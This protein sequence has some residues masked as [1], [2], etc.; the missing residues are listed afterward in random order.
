MNVSDVFESKPFI[1]NPSVIKLIYPEEESSAFDKLGYKYILSPLAES[2]IRQA[3][4]E[5][6]FLTNKNLGLNP[7]PVIV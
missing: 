2:V 6:A 4:E 1:L 3:A 7:N 5:V